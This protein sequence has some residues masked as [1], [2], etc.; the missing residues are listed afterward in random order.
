MLRAF[1]RCGGQPR[2]KPVRREEEGQVEE[3]GVRLAP[4]PTPPHAGLVLIFE[5]EA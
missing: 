2:T 3:L 4:P 1:W 5:R